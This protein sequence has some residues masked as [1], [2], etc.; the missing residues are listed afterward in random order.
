MQDASLGGLF[1]RAAYLPQTMLMNQAQLGNQTNQLRLGQQLG[2]AGLTS[3]LGLGGQQVGTNLE[4]V[5]ADL[6][7]GLFGTLSNAATN[8]GFDPIGDIGAG[9]WDTIGGWLGL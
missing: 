3:Q 5:R 8:S 9:L 4:R 2:L 1:Q 7:A 6:M